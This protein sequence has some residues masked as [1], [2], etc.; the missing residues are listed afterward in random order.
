MINLISN[1]IKYTENGIIYLKFKNCS[2][3]ERFFKFSVRDTG[4]GIKEE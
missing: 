3:D 4:C 1:S 2:E